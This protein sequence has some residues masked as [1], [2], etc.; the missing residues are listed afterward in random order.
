M[1]LWK[2]VGNQL[3]KLLLSE[4]SG[5]SVKNADASRVGHP[6]RRCAGADARTSPLRTRAISFA[7][8]GRGDRRPAAPRR[9]YARAS[10]TSCAASLRC[11][12]YIG[13]ASAETA[14]P[15]SNAPSGPP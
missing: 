12:K 2:V 7:P 6:P 11:S 9:H 4:P 10:M 8:A 14:E 15:A 3:G 1:P 5:I 13:M